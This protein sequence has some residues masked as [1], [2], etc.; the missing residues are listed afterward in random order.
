MKRLSVSIV[1]HLDDEFPGW[2]RAVFTDVHGKEWSIV[3]KVPAFISESLNAS[4]RYPV[5]GFIA[6]TILSRI[7][8]GTREA[9]TIDL[10]Q[11]WGISTVEGQE[12]F[13]VFKEQIT[14]I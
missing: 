8:S 11:P 5:K 6:G 7:S 12:V 13:D 9:V 4:S 14:K 2:V 10:S 3:E 1:E